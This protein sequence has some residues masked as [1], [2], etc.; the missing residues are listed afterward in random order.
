MTHH[1]LRFK[2]LNCFESNADDDDDGSTAK[3]K[4]AHSGERAVYQGYQSDN[5][6][7]QRA[8]QSDSG[9]D[10]LDILCGGC[11]RTD[12]GMVPLLD[13]RLLAISTGLYWMVV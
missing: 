10:P 12:A 5:G 4:S 3:G 2:L 13:F 1:H 6:E 7:E 11:A 8:D 9:E